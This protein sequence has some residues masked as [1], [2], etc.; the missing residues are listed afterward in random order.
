MLTVLNCIKVLQIIVLNQT[1]ALLETQ[2]LG[3]VTINQVKNHQPFIDN[4]FTSLRYRRNQNIL[5]LN[6]VL[7]IQ[8]HLLD[9]KYL[10]R[11]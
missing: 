9:G 5:V 8:E 2:S 1:M 4:L 11:S 10:Q 6:R 3:F 7:G